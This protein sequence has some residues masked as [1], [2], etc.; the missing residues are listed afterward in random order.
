MDA[1]SYVCGQR[2]SNPHLYVGN[3]LFYHL[4]MAAMFI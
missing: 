3:V 4:T 1:F 2:E